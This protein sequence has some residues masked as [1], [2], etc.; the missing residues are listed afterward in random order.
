MRHGHGVNRTSR[1]LLL[2]VLV[3]AVLGPP[4]P[5]Q[6]DGTARHKVEKQTYGVEVR[7]QIYSTQSGGVAYYY[8]AV[9]VFAP[10]NGAEGPT[11]Y[12]VPR[13]SRTHSTPSPAVGPC[14]ASSRLST[15]LV[16]VDGQVGGDPDE[17]RP[18]L[19]RQVGLLGEERLELGGVEGRA[20][21]GARSRPSPG[22]RRSASGT[23]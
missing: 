7:A 13:S 10:F 20:R 19:R 23:A 8:C 1:S 22:R 9:G 16:A 6:A 3:L 12:V 4:S 14:A 17:A 15:L 2:I 21:P 18:A 11:A 5:A